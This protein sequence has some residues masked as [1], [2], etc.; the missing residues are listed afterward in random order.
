MKDKYGDG[1]VDDDRSLGA[2]ALK[3]ADLRTEYGANGIDR[4]RD[5]FSEAE[6]EAASAIGMPAVRQQRGP[7]TADSAS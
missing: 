2:Q 1:L 5:P 4:D 3:A 7:G 6:A